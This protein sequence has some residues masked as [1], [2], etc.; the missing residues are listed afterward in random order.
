MLRLSQS[1]VVE[2]ARLA[3]GSVGPT[4]VVSSAV[5]NLLIGQK[6]TRKNL[7][8][9]AKA[10]RHAVSPIDDIRAS[11]NYRKRVAGNLLLRLKYHNRKDLHTP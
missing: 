10:A 6:L 2:R 3:W 11:S 7:E 5:E 9:A 8:I 4:I 1:G